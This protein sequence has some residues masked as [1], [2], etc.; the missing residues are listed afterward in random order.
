[1]VHPIEQYAIDV[2]I[3]LRL[4]HKLRG[5]DLAKILNT[6]RSFIGNVESTTN[7]AKY[8]LRHLHLMAAYFD[9]SPRIFLPPEPFK[10]TCD[11]KKPLI[12]EGLD[13]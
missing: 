2:A 11:K 8:N 6:T 10:V 3:K 4:K 13:R 1:M 12:F 5:Q 7:A 9:V